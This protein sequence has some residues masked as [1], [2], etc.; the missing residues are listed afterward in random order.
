MPQKLILELIFPDDVD[1]DSEFLFDSHRF[2]VFGGRNKV[3]VHENRIEE[4]DVCAHCF[5][6]LGIER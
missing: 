2:M 3:V 4:S 6:N 1:I 5:D